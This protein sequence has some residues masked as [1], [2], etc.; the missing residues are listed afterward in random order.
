MTAAV[1]WFGR[2]RM[3]SAAPKLAASARG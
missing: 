2:H 3:H 1:Y